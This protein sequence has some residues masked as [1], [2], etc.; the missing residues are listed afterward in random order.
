MQHH[1]YTIA[2]PLIDQLL[3]TLGDE[4]ENTSYCQDSLASVGFETL[5][6]EW[7]TI[8]VPNALKCEPMQEEYSVFPIN[9]CDKYFAE[10]ATI[11]EVLGAFKNGVSEFYDTIE[12]IE[13]KA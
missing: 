10:Y 6:G 5:E 4:W 12:A 3:A 9:V 1:N 2:Q 13:N 11:E 7:V 8:Y